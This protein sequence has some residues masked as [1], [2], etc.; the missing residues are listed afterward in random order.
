ME[1]K[2]HAE[3]EICRH[4]SNMRFKT[5]MREMTKWVMNVM[6]ELV[7]N[8]ILHFVKSLLQVSTLMWGWNEWPVMMTWVG[9]QF[10]SRNSVGW[11]QILKWILESRPSFYYL[12]LLPRQNP[13]PVIL[14]TYQYRSMI[15]KQNIFECS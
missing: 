9:V 6:L 15:W 10:Y 1:K 14:I 12:Y 7:G 4:A 3:A 5:L 11:K 2:E 13:C 8:N